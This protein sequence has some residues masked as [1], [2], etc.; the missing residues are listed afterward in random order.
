M[1]L[2]SYVTNGLYGITNKSKFWL[3]KTINSKQNEAREAK[4]LGKKT[5]YKFKQNKLKVL[6]KTQRTERVRQA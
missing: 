5:K 6:E 4:M 2:S 1:R 3:R